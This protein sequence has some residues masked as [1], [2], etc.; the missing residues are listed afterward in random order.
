MPGT[1]NVFHIHKKLARLWSLK[2]I[3][4]GE[5]LLLKIND[6]LA[7]LE[8][9]WEILTHVKTDG[10]YMYG[11]KTSVPKCIGQEVMYI[12][13]DNPIC[14]YSQRGNVKQSVDWK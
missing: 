8:R 7:C 14:F 5:H 13:S 6:T 1:D 3:T 9:C 10:E 2:G 4:T 11:S 12:S